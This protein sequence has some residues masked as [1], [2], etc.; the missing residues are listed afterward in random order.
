MDGAEVSVLFS[1]GQAATTHALLTLLQ[2]GDE[3]V[4][5]AAIY[6]GTL[7]LIADLL[8]RFGIQG[9]FRVAR[10]A[11]RPGMR[12]WPEDAADLVRIADQPDAALCGRADGGR[13]VPR[14]WRDFGG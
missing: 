14:R 1:S 3:V 10:G 5:S 12:D 13:G 7:H 8:P 4:C 9:T 2:Q 6:G 11:W